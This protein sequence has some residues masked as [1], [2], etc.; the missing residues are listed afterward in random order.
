MTYRYFPID[1]SSYKEYVK[2]LKEE[3]FAIEANKIDNP[4]KD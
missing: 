2:Y 1:Y 4:C 3:G